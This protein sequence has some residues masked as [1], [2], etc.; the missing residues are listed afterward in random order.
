VLDGTTLGC[1]SMKE[2]VIRTCFYHI[3]MILSYLFGY[4]GQVSA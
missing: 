4:I 1:S 2:L 3:R